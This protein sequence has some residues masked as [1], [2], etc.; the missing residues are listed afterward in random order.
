M[1]TYSSKTGQHR[2]AL[3]IPHKSLCVLIVAHIGKSNTM[4][5]GVYIM[6]NHSKPYT[7]SVLLVTT[8]C[9]LHQQKG[10]TGEGG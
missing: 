7:S 4:A 9:A 10:G 2:T 8:Y 3:Y 5:V 1:P 6:V